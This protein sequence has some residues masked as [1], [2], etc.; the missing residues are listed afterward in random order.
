MRQR[1]GPARRCRRPDTVPSRAAG[2]TGGGGRRRRALSAVTAGV[3]W[4]GAQMSVLPAPRLGPR[5]PV[6]DPR[7]GPA[8]GDQRQSARGGASGGD[9]TQ[10]GRAAPP[11]ESVRRGRGSGLAPAAG[12]LCSLSPSS[13]DR[14]Q[15]PLSESPTLGP[16]NWGVARESPR[17]H[18][19]SCFGHFIAKPFWSLLNPSSSFSL[20]L[21]S[22][23]LP[24]L[25]V[26]S[27]S[28]WLLLRGEWGH[29]W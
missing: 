11:R 29:R 8:L 16:G 2:W 19:L 14:F 9:F 4:S 22:S 7:G 27:L 12:F 15:A 28:L 1:P 21:V 3:S 6:Q 5:S 18:Q 26:S 10:H 24:I 17:I 23:R 20:L 13:N 25:W